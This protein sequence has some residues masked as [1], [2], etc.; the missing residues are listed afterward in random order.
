MAGNTRPISAQL[1]VDPDGHI[2]GNI[3]L[4]QSGWG[5]KPYR[6]LMGV[7]KVRDSLEVVFDGRRTSHRAPIRLR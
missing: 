7:L 6:G 5:I 1:G 3:P 2:T 4:T